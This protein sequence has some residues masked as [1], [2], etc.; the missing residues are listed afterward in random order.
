MCV[1]KEDHCKPM[2]K[3]SAQHLEM[4]SHRAFERNCTLAKGIP[5][6]MQ[7]RILS[8]LCNAMHS[9]GEKK[10]KDVSRMLPFVYHVTEYE[11]LL[12]TLGSFRTSNKKN[13][14]T[15]IM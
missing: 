9:F 7:S 11:L 1:S 14:L 4:R 15:R 10:D 3:A 2:R 8:V 12:R 6:Q 13:C 5:Y